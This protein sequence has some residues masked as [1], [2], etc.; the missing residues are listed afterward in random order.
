MTKRI[1]TNIASDMVTLAMSV[2]LVVK[3]VRLVI[4]LLVTV[5]RHPF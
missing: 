2:V 1:G 4:E 5:R 3:L